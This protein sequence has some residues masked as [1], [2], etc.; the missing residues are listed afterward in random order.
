MTVA[1]QGMVQIEKA[2]DELTSSAPRN[3]P[4]LVDRSRRSLRVVNE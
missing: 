2:H 3:A 4:A 1:L